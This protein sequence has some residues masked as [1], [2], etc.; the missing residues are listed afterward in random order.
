MPLSDLD[1]RHARPKD[2]AYRLYDSNGLY[3]EV[4]PTG[5]KVWRLKFKFF[6]KEKLLTIGKYPNTS[7]LDARNKQIEA[8]KQIE[9]GIDPAK[10]KQDEK[11]LYHF[12]QLQTFELVAREW[13]KKNYD[14]WSSDYADEMLRRLE[15]N[16]FPF[17]GKTPISEIRVQDLLVCAQK[18]E[19]RKAHDLT[20][21]V[22]SVIRRIMSYAVI[23]GRVE[24]NCSTD[25][26]GALTKYKKG[27]FASITIEELPGLLVALNENHARLFRQT[28]LAVRL[29]MLTFV[30]TSELI[31]A[32]WNEF[33]LEK[34]VWVIPA[35]RMK[36]KRQHIVPLSLQA[37]GILKELGDKFGYEGYILPSLVKRNKP[38]SNNT[39][40]KALNNLGYGGIMTGHGFRAL[41]MSA[42]KEKLGYRHEVVDRQLAHLPKNRVDQAYDR[43]TFISERAKMMQEWADYIDSLPQ[44]NW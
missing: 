15:S 17:L 20:Y 37:I 33:D 25:L 13:H 34:S 10:L 36:M 1:C 8:R 14:S 18:M 23:T 7:L 3:L 24:F 41:A 31:F 43:A 6:Q 38:I 19:N 4:K 27:H 29:L 35:H 9:S 32:Q 12:N 42:I 11:K 28:I 40:L 26:K 16:V 44:G 21:R 5:T 30:R 2:K 22:I 39:I